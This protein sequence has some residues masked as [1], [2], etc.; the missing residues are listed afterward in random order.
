MALLADKDGFLV[1]EPITIDTGRFAKAA[2]IWRAIRED[3]LAIRR[4][5]SGLSSSQ[6]KV[7]SKPPSS[8][9]V[10]QRVSQSRPGPSILPARNEKGQFI[11]RDAATA[12]AVPSRRVASQRATEPAALMAPSTP[13]ALPERNNRGRFVKRN[14]GSEEPGPDDNP[15]DPDDDESKSLLRRLVGSMAEATGSGVAQ[16]V[17]GADQ[18]DPTL[19]AAKEV[20][21]IVGPLF[22]PIGAAFTTV[23]NR[24]AERK[25]QREA[26]KENAKE[27][28]KLAVPWYKRMI[29]RKPA[30]AGNGGSSTGGLIGMLAGAL[31]MLGGLLAGAI[32]M[33]IA[34]AGVL[35]AGGLGAWLGSKIGGWINDKFGMQISDAIWNASEFIK[36]KWSGITAKWDALLAKMSAAADWVR[37]VK[38]SVQDRASKTKNWLSDQVDAVK[39]SVGLGSAGNRRALERHLDA[40]GIRNKS[41]RDMIMAQAHHETGGFRNMEEGFNYS[42]D[43]LR[44][45]SRRT[46]GMSDAQLK[47]IT[48]SGP[49]GIAE[50][51]YGGRNGNSQ[52]GDGYRYRGRGYVQLTGRGNY[53]AASK[54][55]GI[56][57]VANPDLAAQPDIAARIATWYNQHRGLTGAARR[58]DVSAVTRCINGGLMGLAERKDLYERYSGASISSASPVSPSARRAAPPS[59]APNVDKYQPPKPPELLTPIGSRER[60][61]TKVEVTVPMPVSQNVADRQ[62]AQLATGGMGGNGQ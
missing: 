44:Q 27:Q 20:G 38:S 19:T 17:E 55:L 24:R 21:S 50:F 3:T 35:I 40:A 10:P 49:S 13:A 42:P 62:I 2:S 59:A 6:R 58:G 43:R 45:V 29:G 53:A 30:T 32:P 28:H 39:S 52:Q 34:G 23:F 8:V 37:G 60:N 51:M 4:A 54:A 18:I 25:K 1:G 11:R 46:R 12:V 26:A 48:D 14:G 5:L 36:E 47:A 7:A 56:D 22:K 9:A 16:S 31:P 57:L 15:K 61:S 33:L 41:E